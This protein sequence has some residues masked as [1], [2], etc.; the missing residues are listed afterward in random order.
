[1]RT[2]NWRKRGP[3]SA[4]QA[5]YHLAEIGSQVSFCGR[6]ISCYIEYPNGAKGRQCVFCA[7]NLRIMRPSPPDFYDGVKVTVSVDSAE[8]KALL[9]DLRALLDVH[10]TLWTATMNSYEK[11]FARVVGDME[12]EILTRKESTTGNRRGRRTKRSEESYAE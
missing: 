9:S 8:A 12:I 11:F 1:M 7:E 10:G 4:S 5:V 3:V 2:T 6:D